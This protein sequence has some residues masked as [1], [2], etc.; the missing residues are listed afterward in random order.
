MTQAYHLGAREISFSL[1]SEP[2]MSQ[3]LE[4]CVSDAKNIGYEYIYLT[5]N[6]SMAN[7]DR[8]EQLF[9]NGLNSIKFSVNAGT[10]E[11]YIKVHGRDDFQKVIK[12]I[13][14]AVQLRK[15]MN[16]DVGIFVSFVENVMTKGH[17][18]FLENILK[19]KVDHIYIVP[20]INQG[21]SMYE[22]I[23]EGVVDINKEKGGLWNRYEKENKNIK[24]I[25]P[26]PFNR[27][28]IT[29]EG[30]LTACCVDLKN[31]LVVAD[32]NKISLQDAWN[33]D[34]MKKLRSFHLNRTIPQ[35]LKCY[36]CLYNMNNII[37]PI[38]EW[39]KKR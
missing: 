36:N 5:T 39:T 29:A 6:G 12:N 17:G 24:T 8:L 9:A 34:K 1:I 37:E 14:S 25:C 33:C 18:I 3:A 28:N 16:T 20:A 23:Q 26:Y 19:N 7:K 10:A 11:I 13:I 2:F 15:E 22:E 30:Y 32:L 38:C 35:N 4:D 21:G 27:I 31:E